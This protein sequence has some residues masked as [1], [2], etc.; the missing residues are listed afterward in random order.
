M[1]VQS[2]IDEGR[3]IVERLLD[4]P[5]VCFTDPTM[6]EIPN[7]SGIYTFSN[8]ETQEVLYVGLSNR[9]LRNH[10]KDHWYGS[11]Q[12][13]L[14]RTLIDEGVVQNKTESKEWISANV[15]IR[16]MTTDEFGM[17]INSA[18]KAVIDA[19]SPKYNKQ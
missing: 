6:H 2:R 10:M 14:A 17:N 4:K 13:D 15:V 5:S 7:E 16:Y 12:S 8:R 18:K 11:A 9:G 1:N 3:N 19:L